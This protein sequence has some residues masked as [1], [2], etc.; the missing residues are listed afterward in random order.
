VVGRDC[1]IIL[2]AK[3]SRSTVCTNRNLR[4]LHTYCTGN[5]TWNQNDTI[6]LFANIENENG[7]V[8]SLEWCYLLTCIKCVGMVTMATPYALLSNALREWR[9]CVRV[10]GG[11]RRG[12]E[13]SPLPPSS[14]QRGEPREQRASRSTFLWREWNTAITPI[15]HVHT[16][17]MY[18]CSDK[19]A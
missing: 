3:F 13:G 19:T 8:L 7:C 4:Y 12:E 1:E 2:P 15:T 18:T 14:S 10:R 6:I 16:I 11:G 9:N 17:Y 5:G